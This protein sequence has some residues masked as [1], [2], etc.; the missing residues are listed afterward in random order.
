M[1][2]PSTLSAFNRPAATDRLNSPSHSAL[3][4]DVSSAVGQ[5]EQ[6][7]GL[8]TTS[9]VGSLFYDIRSSD[10]D[11]GGHVQSANKGGTG[12]TSFTK[13][14]LLVA[15]SSSVL[16]KL[17][18]GL[19]GQA[20][21]ANSSV[22][23]GVNWAVAG[24]KLQNVASIITFIYNTTSVMQT[25]LV[26]AT[27]P[28]STLGTSGMLRTTAYVN[29]YTGGV[30]GPTSILVSAHYAGNTV[31]SILIRG[32][33]TTASLPPIKGKIEYALYANNSVSVQR[34]ILNIDLFAERTDPVTG[35]IVGITAYDTNTSSV[36]SSADQSF[37]ITGLGGGADSTSL[38]IGA[39]TIEK[40]I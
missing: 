34:A 15:T 35:S 27:I 26:S 10:S 8:S 5:I 1:P 37:G 16:A 21:V 3:H 39:S 2:F 30:G 33:T 14:D 22:A 28:G 40:I 36:E 4:N 32:A 38:A 23:T 7:I 13:G 24:V 29:T 12:Q 25:S 18:V 19:D 6:L 17:A 31:A 20:L 11:G 9:V